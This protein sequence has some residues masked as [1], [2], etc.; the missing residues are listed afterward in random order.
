MMRNKKS[1]IVAAAKATLAG[2]VLLLIPGFLAVFLLGKVFNLLRSV[3]TRLGP[4]LGIES[5]L[6]GLLLDAATIVAILLACFL[7]GLLA[8]RSGA[9]RLRNKMDQ[10]LLATLPGYAFIKGVAE[11]MQQSQEIASSFVPVLVKFDDYWQ[12]AFETDRKPDGIVAIYLPGAP[13]P[14]SGSVI[15]V[16]AERVRKL[17][18]SATDALKTIRTLGRGAEAL[19]GEFRTLQGA[20]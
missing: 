15:F 5:R 3:A 9:K 8:R 6:G 1:S 10:V 17:P 13:N 4:L 7:A 16:L 19:A 12:M 11:N 20:R 14:W 2:G 18:L